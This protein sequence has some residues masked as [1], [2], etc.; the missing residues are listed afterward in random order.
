MSALVSIGIPVYNGE[1]TLRAAIES[2]LKQSYKNLEIIISDN[3]STDDT[4]KI[5]REYQAADSRVHYFRQPKNMGL[6]SNIAFVY[7]N[8]KGEYFSWAACDDCRSKDFIETNVEFLENNLQYV[9]STSPNC[10]VGSE[11]KMVCYSITG[12]IKERLNYFFKNCMISHG[13][14]YSV[15]RASALRNFP[16]FS[17]S[18]LALDW[19][20]NYYLIC[21]G[22]IHRQSKGLLVLGVSGI[23]KGKNAYSAFHN[24]FV[25]W[26]FPLFQFSLFV[27][28]NSDHFSFENK[29]LIF[30]YLVK[31]NFFFA[32]DKLIS[33][34]YRFYKKIFY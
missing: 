8:A 18:Y 29:I 3:S 26:I 25:E 9:A 31:L 30:N 1:K 12:S 4:E 16:H 17:Q 33:H 19:S 27:L 28:K 24:S 7:H 20:V 23:S 11:S 15:M 2:I 21:Q 32:K 22:P 6:Y 34:L 14:F 5:C 10:F 13:I